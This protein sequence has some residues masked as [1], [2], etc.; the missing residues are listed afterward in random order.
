MTY[1][2]LC[3]LEAVEKFTGKRGNYKAFNVTENKAWDSLEWEV[4]KFGNESLMR[5]WSNE[6]NK[7]EKREWEK[8]NDRN[9]LRVC[10]NSE[11]HGNPV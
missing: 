9:K 3:T 1:C 6:R 2:F 8:R 7:S 10:S 11:F 4:W 5:V